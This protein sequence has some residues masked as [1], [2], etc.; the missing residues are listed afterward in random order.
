[1]LK[2]SWMSCVVPHTFWLYITACMWKVCVMRCV[3]LIFTGC[4]I[5][6]VASERLISSSPGCIRSNLHQDSCWAFISIS[7][8]GW[9]CVCVL[10]TFSISLSN[11]HLHQGSSSLLLSSYS[12]FSFLYRCHRSDYSD[13]QRSDGFGRWWRR[14][15]ADGGV[16]VR[17]A[18]YSQYFTRNQENI[19]A[20]FSNYLLKTSWNDTFI[21]LLML[22]RVNLNKKALHLLHW[23]ALGWHDGFV[24]KPAF[25]SVQWFYMYFSCFLFHTNSLQSDFEDDAHTRTQVQCLQTTKKQPK[26][27][28]W[29]YIFTYEL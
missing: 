4:Q 15:I 3:S 5:V 10:I 1:M 22:R 17:A 6:C 20:A 16:C 7:F 29:T 26:S 8:S 11:H 19:F 24:L 25:I 27:D 2:S 13:G 23:F 21:Y 14:H 12:G 9:R 28:I 18:L